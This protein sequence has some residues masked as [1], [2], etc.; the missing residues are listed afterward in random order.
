MNRILST[1]A[2]IALAITREAGDLARHWFDKSTLRVD[3][4]SDG[5]PVTQADQEIE[6]MIRNALSENFPDDGIMGEEFDDIEGSSGNRW[7]IDPIDGTKSF[8]HS[9][10]LYANLLAYEEAG[11]IT[12]GAI[13]LPSA[14]VLVSA[15]KGGGCWRNDEPAAVSD[16]TDLDGAYLMATWLE[17]WKP[18][19]IRDLNSRGV[20]LRTWG[21]AY[22]YAMVACGHAD[23]IVDYT[24]K[25][26]DLAPMPVIIE[27]AGGRFSSLD[28][29]RN[30]D[31][32]NG[33]ASN[34]HLHDSIRQLVN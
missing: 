25:A 9:V 11:E 33:I 5:S 1:R 14:G 17:D 3:T 22:G 32:G 24:T 10:P 16:R 31:C 8:V 23:A 28:G 15:E 21:D 26:Y 12:F 18:D 4:K 6:Q 13:N 7:I 34:G 27:E 29:R 2:E 19:T 20:I 30:F